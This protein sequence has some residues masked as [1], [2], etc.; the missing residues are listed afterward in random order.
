MGND[1][2]NME[3]IEGL[4]GL[5][6]L[7]VGYSPNKEYL[8]L[9]QGIAGSP[10]NKVDEDIEHFGL[11]PGIAITLNPSPMQPLDSELKYANEHNLK[12]EKVNDGYYQWF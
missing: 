8:K 3:S 2:K 7:D 12:I 4:D 9:T 11:K 5:N 6:D 1:W 10:N